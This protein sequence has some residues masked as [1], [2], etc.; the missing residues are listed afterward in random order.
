MF[1]SIWHRLSNRNPGTGR[2]KP[3]VGDRHRYYRP[4]LDSLEDRLLPATLAGGVLQ[5]AAA[6]RAIAPPGPTTVGPSVVGVSKLAVESN[7]AAIN[8]I[9]GATNTAAAASVSG[10]QPINSMPLGAT[11]PIRVTVA[12]NSPNST[13][14]LGAIFKAMQGLRYAGGLKLSVIGNTN[15]GL[16][17][18]ELSGTA[19]TLTYAR[20]KYGTAT[21]TV[22]A[23][24]ADGVS[25][26]VTFF[27]TVSPLLLTFNPMQPS[28]VR[29]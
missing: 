25:R 9:G 28:T 1:L 21:I 18:T 15:S 5:L 14:D 10:L 6:G 26:Q 2:V 11:P 8:P 23:T 27:V 22:C 16:V 20:G 19:L 7:G 4:R 17:G 13:I 12:A 3:R 29:G 24:D